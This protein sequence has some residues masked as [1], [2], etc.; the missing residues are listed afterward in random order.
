MEDIK[1]NQAHTE[2]GALYRLVETLRGKNGCPWDKKQTP[3]SVSIYL[4]EEVFEL[5]HAIE[6]AEPDQIR[7][8]LGDVLFHIVFIARMF[9]ER[10]HFDLAAVAHSITEKMIR[11][12]PHVFGGKKIHSSEE[13][14][15]NWHKIKL[16]EKKSTAKHS[17]LDSVP[18][19]LPALL[20]AYRVS[21]RVAKST[22][23][24]TDLD[25]HL[26]N[27]QDA[28]D[29]LKL[30]LK[31]QETRISS[32]QIG[33]LLFAAVNLARRAKIHPERALAESVKRFEQRFKMI[34]EL[35]SESNRQFEELTIEEKKR[36]WEKL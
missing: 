26:N 12:H 27:V 16:G 28:L 34:E 14:I 18:P 10:G 25:S 17:L 32:E 7:D 30:I 29:K 23:E 35:I 6:T 22:F 19:N 31:S 8:E 36:I 9:Q 3:E 5:A 2:L 15:D 33:D 13:V 11:R 21:D 4:M 24:E 1:L 20:R